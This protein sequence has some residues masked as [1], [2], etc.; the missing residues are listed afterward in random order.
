MKLCQTLIV[1]DEKEIRDGLA[2]WNWMDVGVEIVACC[3]HGI[4]ALRYI[5]S[6]PVDVVIADIRM[7][8]MGGL[9]LL[10]IL[11]NEYAFIKVIILS[12]YDEFSY[13]RKSLQLRA[14]DYLLK[15]VS[16]DELKRAVTKSFSYNDAAIE[17][18]HRLHA[19]KQKSFELQRILRNSF[20]YNL[21]SGQFKSESTIRVEGSSD[22]FTMGTL[23]MDA[24]EYSAGIIRLDRFMDAASLLKNSE[25]EQLSFALDF[26]LNRHWHHRFGYYL[27]DRESLEVLLL[28]KGAASRQALDNLMQSLLDYKSLF[29]STF[30][31]IAGPT[32]TSKEDVAVSLKIARRNLVKS[33]AN[34]IMICEPAGQDLPLREN[35]TR[36]FKPSDLPNDKPES[37]ILIAAKKYIE[38]NY[39]DDLTLDEVAEKVYVS[40]HYLSALFKNSGDTFLKYLTSTRITTAKLN[41]RNLRYKVYEVADMVGYQDPAYFS[42]IFKKTTGMT[43]S[44][45]RSVVQYAE[46]SFRE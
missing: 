28:I 29:K 45:Y 31:I 36:D 24:I 37:A 11:S 10:E 3:S 40:P 25:S 16:E 8:F 32:V 9:E 22:W 19:L 18:E 39:A 42:E 21:F 14:D 34:S 33:D 41:L 13:A 44:E 38:K 7:P 1:D 23:E 15:P 4:E 20:L 2:S 43:P 30:T 5:S 6:H 27:V 12:A 46:E 17:A 26:I 35:Q